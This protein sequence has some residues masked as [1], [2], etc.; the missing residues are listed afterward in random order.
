MAITQERAEQAKVAVDL[1]ATEIARTRNPATRK[2]LIMKRAGSLALLTKYNKQ[3][4]RH[5]VNNIVDTCKAVAV[6][7][8]KNT[9]TVHTPYKLPAINTCACA[10]EDTTTVSRQDEPNLYNGNTFFRVTWAKRSR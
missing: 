3:Q 2:E 6:A 9:G 1:L 10:T 4:K 8:K 7:L 5:I